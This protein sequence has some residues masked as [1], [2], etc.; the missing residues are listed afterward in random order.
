MIGSAGT[1]EE[2]VLASRHLNPDVIIMDVVLPDLS[3]IEATRRILEHSPDIRVIALSARHS[4]EHVYRAL[5]AGARGYVLE[6][7]IAV[8]AVEASHKPE[9]TMRMEEL[10]RSADRSLLENFAIDAE[11]SDSDAALMSNI[12]RAGGTHG[13]N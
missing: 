3:G 9:S 8:T 6:V 12:G 11:S 5:R 4:L 2:A 7:S 13:L 10:V 1:G